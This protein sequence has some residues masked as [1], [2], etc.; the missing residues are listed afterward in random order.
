MRN[1]RWLFAVL[2]IA[3]A[4]GLLAAQQT[5]TIQGVV[6]DL[7][8]VPVSGAQVTVAGTGLGTLS[9]AVG[10]FQILNV[11]AGA[12][13]L[14]VERI[15]FT[16]VTRDVTVAAGEVAT[17][18]VRL[19]Q[20]A[21]GL[22]GIVVTGVAE[23]TPRVKLPITVEQ[24]VAADLP[25]P[26]VS[27]GSAI[28]GKVAGAQVVQGTGRPGAA[29]S[30]LLRGPT[31]INTAGRNQ[32]PLW[33]VDGVILSA[34]MV[35]ID[36]LDIENIEVVKGAAAAS[37]YGSRAAAG[38]IQVTTRRGRALQDDMIRYTVRSEFGQSQLPGRFNLTQ[39]H[40]FAMTADGSRFIDPEG[41]PCA[42]L[43]CSNVSLAGQRAPEGATV[44]DWNTVMANTWPGVT[45][46]HVAEF[47]TGGRFMQNYL[48]AEGRS[49]ATNY[50]VSFSQL[51]DQGVMPGQGGFDRQNFR[52][53]IDQSVR[54]DITLSGSAFYSASVQDHFPESQGNPIFNLTRMP[55][56]VN[57]RACID[58]PTADCSGAED[59]LDRLIIRPDP[60]N[61]ND[62]PLYELLNREYEQRRGRFLGTANVRYRPTN[63]FNVDANVSYDRLDSQWED[64]YPLGYR[65]I[66]G[67]QEEGDLYRYHGRTEGLNASLTGTFRTTLGDWGTNRTQVRYL[68]DQS[69]ATWTSSSGWGFVVGGVPHFGNIPSDNISAGSGLQKRRTDGY[70]VITDFDVMDRYILSALVR[71]DGSSLFGPDE[72]RQWYYRLAGAWRLTEEPWM[73]IPAFQELKLRYSLGTAGG[74][75]SWAAQYETYSVAAGRVSPITLGNREL[76]PEFSTEHEVGLEAF[77]LDRFDLAVN[78]ATTTTEDQILNVPL[79]PYLGFGSQWQ[80]AGTL[81]S[82]TWEMSLGARLVT[83][84]DL[85]WSARLLFDRTRQEITQLNRPSYVMGVGG[86]AMGDVFYVREGEVLGTFY[87]TQVAS[88]CD[89]LPE[90]MSCDGFMVNDDGFLVWVGDA[91]HYNNGWGTAPEG[92]N[93][94]GTTGPEIAGV[95]VNWGS[96][97]VGRCIDRETG[98]E[99]TFCPLG[100]TT[101]D[102]NVGLS[103][104]MNWR[105]FSVYG[106]LNAVQ[107]FSI[108]NQPLQW[109]VFQNY[110]GIMDQSDV[111]A[112]QQ[113][114]LGYFAQLYGVSGLAPSSAFVDDGSFVKLRELAVS[115]RF[116]GATLAGLPILQGF[117][118]ITL[119]AVGRNL[120]T[121]TDYDGYDP[122]VGRTGGHTGSAAL[123]RVD[124]FNYPNFRT[125]TFGL[126]LNF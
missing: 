30:V 108:Y 99:T 39:R 42:W 35:D 67:L 110:A 4:P 22:T 8:N 94:W 46:D 47:F 37:L 41:N 84:P 6:T 114:P 10:R 26:A 102:Y 20:V 2:A 12:H 104:T 122:E 113:K 40:P 121:W 61:E 76:R 116:D 111:P 85:T 50:H 77:F 79:A 51:D 112:D 57:L 78:Y 18:N 48:S 87:G 124:G 15:G 14:R 115:Y 31:S 105:G 17:A 27:A 54:P 29:A 91:G 80:N 13:Q 7:D 82:N 93:W 92:G 62:N 25:V 95:N 88:S 71:N 74:H 89:H 43:E 70:F 63:W 11:P 16:E 123:A 106:L 9:D 120:F 125:F 69:D 101:P 32:E 83:T 64:H 119:S 109:A 58:D 33:I 59:R 126:E 81:D 72:R 66:R 52:I 65:S 75:P 90:G 38:V 107:G 44:N 3:V 45:H 96:P 21:V 24:L 118:G 28:Q 97:I 86:Q 73:N 5:G 53:N 23:A 103:S 100:N 98:E 55:A 36:A 117:D 68:W 60:F 34:S 49:G 19:Q 56:G 1:L